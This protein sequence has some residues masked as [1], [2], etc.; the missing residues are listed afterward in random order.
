MNEDKKKLVVSLTD[1]VVNDIDLRS[2]IDTKFE[3]DDYESRTKEIESI[4]DLIKKNLR[5]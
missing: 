2:Y 5:G 4:L 3:S 1:R